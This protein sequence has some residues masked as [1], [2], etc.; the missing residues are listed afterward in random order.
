MSRPSQGH[1]KESQK[2]I[3]AWIL[4]KRRFSDG[5]RRNICDISMQVFFVVTKSIN[6]VAKFATF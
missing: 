5:I 2:L 6:F 4:C 1:K 3:N